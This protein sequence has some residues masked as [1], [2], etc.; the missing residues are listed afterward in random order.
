[1]QANKSYYYA[2]NNLDF[3]MKTGASWNKS[4][5]IY[6]SSGQEVNNKISPISVGRCMGW[7]ISNTP[8]DKS[9]LQFPEK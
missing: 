3:E 9:K 5:L 2:E 6:S 1:M 4:I 7:E 8:S